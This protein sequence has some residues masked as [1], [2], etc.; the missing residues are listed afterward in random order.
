MND[1]AIKILEIAEAKAT[2]IMQMAEKRA[3]R[4]H[5]ERL[6]LMVSTIEKVVNGKI[7]SLRIE[8]HD[9]RDEDKAWKKE[10]EPYL[11]G[12]ANLSGSA[13][14]IVWVAIGVS[15]LIG[16]WIAIRSLIK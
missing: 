4:H 7:D 3:E 14:I 15:S 5:Q 1:E 2:E 10:N 8:F 13:K 9:Y 12:L 16:A 11:R 6:D